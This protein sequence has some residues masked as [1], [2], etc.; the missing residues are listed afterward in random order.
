MLLEEFLVDA[1]LERG[2]LL[3]SQL[4]GYNRYMDAS[5]EECD[6]GK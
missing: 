3:L 2:G 6:D 4:K 5:F 1:I